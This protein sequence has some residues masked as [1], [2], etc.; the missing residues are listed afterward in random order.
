MKKNE[1]TKKFEQF[2]LSYWNGEQKLWKAFWII[3]I[4]G[5]ILLA[6]FVIFFAILGKSLGLTWSITILSFILV[7]IYILWSF[8]SIWKCAFNVKN[9][10]WGYAARI[11]ISADLIAGIYQTIIILN[12]TN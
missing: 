3:G 8:V 12:N 9:K 10:T 4:I 6:S 11:F 7:I 2:L 1:L 5:R